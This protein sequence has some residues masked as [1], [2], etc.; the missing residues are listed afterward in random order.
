MFNFEKLEAWQH[1][2]ELADS[3]YRVTRGFPA[4][5]R[6]GLTT[7]MRRAAVSVSPNLAK[8][9]SQGRIASGLRNSLLNL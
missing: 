9:S 6:F 5:E 1:A 2:I 3:V 7:Q 8:G 4:E